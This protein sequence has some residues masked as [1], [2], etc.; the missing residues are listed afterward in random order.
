MVKYKGKE[1]TQ[2]EFDKIIADAENAK[3]LVGGYDKKIEDLQK[4][5]DEAD[6]SGADA[7]ELKKLLKEKEDEVFKMKLT[8][9][10]KKVSKYIESKEN[11][12]T[13]IQK[14]GEYTDEDFEMFAEGKTDDEFKSKD[15]IESAQKDLD[16]KTKDLENNKDK[17]IDDAIKA[18]KTEDEKKN[19]QKVVPSGEI[20]GEKPEDKKGKSKYPSMDTIVDLYELK[21]DPAFD[22]INDRVKGRANSYIKRMLE[23]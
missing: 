20:E 14:I 19:D 12:K 13:L 22:T 11:N 2:E 8:D 1:I 5:I 3:K 10:L 15:E 9:R 17:I 7:A 4:K 21:D 23:D 16:Q 6:A 18:R